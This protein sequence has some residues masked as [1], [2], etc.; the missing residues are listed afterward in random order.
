L[1]DYFRMRRHSGLGPFRCDF[2]EIGGLREQAE[3]VP[4]SLENERLEKEKA[5][6]IGDA[7]RHVA[8]V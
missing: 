7:A 6:P 8:K 2:D 1:K 4:A 5:A 3:T